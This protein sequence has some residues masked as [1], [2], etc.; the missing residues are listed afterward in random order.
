MVIVHVIPTISLWTNK[1]MNLVI[2]YFVTKV[3]FQATFAEFMVT[4]EALDII[5]LVVIVTYLT[6]NV[7]L[8]EFLL[9]T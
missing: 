6:G 1:S 8:I 9:I 2:F 5:P 4:L 7:F 3:C